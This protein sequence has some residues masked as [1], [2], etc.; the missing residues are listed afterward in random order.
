M[1]GIYLLIKHNGFTYLLNTKRTTI[2]IKRRQKI[3][4]VNKSELLTSIKG[5]MVLEDI[6]QISE[7][8]AIEVL[9]LVR[10]LKPEMPKT[11]LKLCFATPVN[12]DLIKYD[13]TSTVFNR[14]KY[15]ILKRAFMNNLTYDH[16]YL[17]LCS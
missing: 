5:G 9:I 1:Q 13:K 15:E 11:F 4:S 6:Q 2:S 3:Q 8:A 10:I 7:A 12:K 16:K 17:Q 14:Y